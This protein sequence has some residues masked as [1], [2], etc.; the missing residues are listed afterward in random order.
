MTLQAL[1]TEFA[2]CTQRVSQTAVSL[3]VQC[4]PAQPGRKASGSAQLANT[5]LL[6]ISEL[7]GHLAD[8]QCQAEAAQQQRQEAVLHLKEGLRRG[9]SSA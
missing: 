3:P 4:I 9:E 2:E 1:S 6:Q 7:E 5:F 8:L